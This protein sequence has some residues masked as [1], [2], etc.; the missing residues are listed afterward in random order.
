M[1]IVVTNTTEMKEEE[2]KD[3]EMDFSHLETRNNSEEDK[4]SDD[5]NPDSITINKKWILEALKRVMLGKKGKEEGLDT[6][7]N[8][9]TEYG[10]NN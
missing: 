3:D 9:S 10:R 5:E 7:I 4:N 2:K 8:R 1:G 6:V